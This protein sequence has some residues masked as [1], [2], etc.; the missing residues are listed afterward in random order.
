MA[1]RVIGLGEVLWDCAPAGRTLGGAPA[2]FAFHATQLGA[3][4]MVVSR[5]GAD[6]LGKELLAELRRL[7]LGADFVQCDADAPTGTVDLTL[8]PSGEPTYVIHENVA[9]DRLEAT[10]AAAAALAGA[11]AVCFGS[12]A[13]RQPATRAAIHAL[14]AAAPT[15]ALRIF[16]VNL[17]QHFWTPETLAA[18]FAA[19]NLAKVNAAE[20]ETL[21]AVFSLPAGERQRL[22]A[23]AERFG[24]RAAI[25]TCGAA[26]SVAFADGAWSESPGVP[27]LVA[28]TI[29]AGDSFTAAFALGLLR[30]RPL[31]E[32]HA[33]AAAVAAFVCSQ[34]GATPALPAALKAGAVGP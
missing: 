21:A 15:A 6:A 12:L 27:T 14:L 7:G 26:G 33:R 18:S 5:V 30:H 32:I 3:E 24:L 28:D 25:C 29:G 1:L 10:P 23:L 4:G 19:A 13:Q 11:N 9:W 20:L 2:N 8:G 31:A 22:A 16:D 34:A 17:R